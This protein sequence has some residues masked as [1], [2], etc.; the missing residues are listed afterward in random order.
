MNRGHTML[1]IY[2][3]QITK[4]IPFRIRDSIIEI[5]TDRHCNIDIY[6]N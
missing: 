2:F 3:E 1:D 4:H 6:S 5:G